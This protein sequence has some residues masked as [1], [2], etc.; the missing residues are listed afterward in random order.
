[1]RAAATSSPSR[2]ASRSTVARLHAPG[3]FPT[4]LP[5]WPGMKRPLASRC[6]PR[7]EPTIFRLHRHVAYVHYMFLFDPKQTFFSVL[8]PSAQTLPPPASARGFQFVRFT[9]DRR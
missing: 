2:N 5:D 8:V 3:F 7:V 1:M 4:G 6:T 9:A